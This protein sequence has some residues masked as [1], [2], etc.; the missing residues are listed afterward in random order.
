MVIRKCDRCGA[1][2]E[3]QVVVQ[4]SYR[5][6]WAVDYSKEEHQRDYGDLCLPC[7]KALLE[8]VDDRG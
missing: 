4:G 3:R 5:I 8:M 2:V 1:E 7:L 6:S